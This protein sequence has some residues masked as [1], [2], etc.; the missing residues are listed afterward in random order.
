MFF[1]V[2]PGMA[3]FKR[4]EMTGEMYSAHI[5]YS[6]LMAEHG[7]FGIMAILIIFLAPISYF[8]KL[9]TTDNRILLVMCVAF[10]CV[11]LAHS[12]MRIA[13]PGFIYGMAYINF[14]RKPRV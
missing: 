5:E 6:R 1:G 10:T 12:A 7:I 8:F 13:A 3:E 2:G 14:I 4:L 11:T 9:K